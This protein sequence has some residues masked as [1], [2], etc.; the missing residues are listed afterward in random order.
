MRELF[1]SWVWVVSL[2]VLGIVVSA[3]LGLYGLTIAYI[4]MAIGLG[5]AELVEKARTG[6]TISENIGRRIDENGLVGVILL[7]LFIITAIGLVLHFYA[8]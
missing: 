8:Y 4:L 2:I 5:L 7:V 1:K 3:A 6:R